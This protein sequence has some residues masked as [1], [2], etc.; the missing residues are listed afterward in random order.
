MVYVVGTTPFCSYLQA[1]DHRW[2][3]GSRSGSWSGGGHRCSGCAGGASPSCCHHLASE[4]EPLTWQPLAPQ[5]TGRCVC[6][7]VCVCVRVCVC[8]CVCACVC[9]CV[10]VCMCV[11]VGV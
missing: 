1:S 7:C 8:V 10:C 5:D 4:E 3:N 9:V 2:L 6:V 11:C